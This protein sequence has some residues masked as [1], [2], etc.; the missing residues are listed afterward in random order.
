MKQ[1]L[2]LLSPFLLLVAV[3]LAA[4]RGASAAEASPFGINVHAP[5]GAELAAQLDKVRAAGIGWVR[6]DF[7]WAWVEPVRGKYDWR[8]YDAIANAAAARGLKVFATIAYTPA[9]ATDGPAITGVPRNPD[10]WRRFCFRAAKRYRRT[11]QHWGMWNE[12]N[13]PRFWSGSRQQYVD[14]ILKTGADAIHT[15]NPAAKVGGPDLAHLTTGDS[16]WYDWLRRTLLEAGDRLD[17]I[18]HHV[19]DTDGNRDVTSKLEAKTLFG[20]RP[21]LW[22]AV[23]PSVKEVLRNT[24]WLGRKP[25]WLT[26]TGWESARV[27]EDRQSAYYGGLLDDWFTGRSGR[28]WVD[29]VFFYELQ[30]AP[31]SA[32]GL[33]WGI[34]RSNGTPKPAFEGYQV[35]IKSQL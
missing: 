32:G 3:L 22:D 19:Y 8:A 27:S 24:G 14:V 25:F 13:L 2:K 15:G 21:S 29:K 1:R 33:S 17:F 31:A 11:I 5:Q 35:F 10:D 20:S 7:I 4:A 30:D 34:L 6:I 12:P 18:T 9:W 23:P 26:E 28:D 16:D